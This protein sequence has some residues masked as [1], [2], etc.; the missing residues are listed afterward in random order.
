M[1]SA[2]V[3]TGKLLLIAALTAFSPLN[4]ADATPESTCKAAADIDKRVNYDFCVSKLLAHHDSTEADA[5]GLAQI[6]A[7]I[8]ANNAGDAMED[9]KA[10]LAKPGTGEKERSVLGHAGDLYD[11]V[12][13]AFIVAHDHIN[14][15]RYAAGKEK[16][17]ETVGFVRQCDEAF[18]KAG[19]SSLLKRESADSVQLA[20]ICT[21]ITN[22]IK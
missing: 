15:R 10:L 19:V 13:T 1:R 7:L 16:V 3:P 9:I 11:R 4:C 14:M 5:W 6:S 17:A 21:A 18:A 8:G 22:L 2:R 20:I 12:A